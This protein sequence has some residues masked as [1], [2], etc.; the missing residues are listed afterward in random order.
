MLK[1][2]SII[3]G[4]IILFGYL[5][6]GNAQ[7][8][9]IRDVRGPITYPMDPLVFGLLILIFGALLIFAAWIFLKKRKMKQVILEN[10]VK[11][12]WQLA[13][14]K[15]D[16]LMKKSYLDQNNFDQFYT[17]LS[18]ILRSYLEDSFSIR[19]PEMTTEEF[20]ISV[21][22]NE[23]L[24]NEQI[25]LLQKFLSYADMV[26]FARFVPTRTDAEE[27][28]NLAKEFIQGTKKE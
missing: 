22:G 7:E 6:V 10:E 4:F 13:L 9:D 14:E 23:L 25:T 11:A 27:G 5:S 8:G 15:L 21:K 24:S 1:V 28:Y 26:K 16:Q 18:D 19:A 2:F 12:P 17:E 20:L 3:I